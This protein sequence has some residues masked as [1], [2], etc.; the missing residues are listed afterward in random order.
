MNNYWTEGFFVGKIWLC[1]ELTNDIFFLEQGIR[2]SKLMMKCIDEDESFDG[3][4][5]DFLFSLSLNAAY[6]SIG[7]EIYKEHLIKATDK[8]VKDIENEGNLSK[9]G[10]D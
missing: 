8:C 10:E 9:V 5:L 1:Y 7:D 3:H 6:Q 2:Y 4:D